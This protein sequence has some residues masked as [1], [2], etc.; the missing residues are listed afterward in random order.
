M[1]TY[2]CYALVKLHEIMH[3]IDTLLLQQKKFYNRT[4]IR[5]SQL[6]KKLNPLS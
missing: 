3:F 1:D 2:K 6:A 4:R 5:V